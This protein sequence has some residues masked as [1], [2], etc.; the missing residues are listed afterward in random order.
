M[1][2]PQRQSIAGM[3]AFGVLH[4]EVKMR[5]NPLADTATYTLPYSHSSLSTR[6]EGMHHDIII[7]I[8]A[9]QHKAKPRI[10]RAGRILFLH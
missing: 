4:M 5:F 2:K 7:P 3:E 10:E 8:F 9:H 6:L 1:R